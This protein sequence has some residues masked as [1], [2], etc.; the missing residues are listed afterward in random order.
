M[1]RNHVLEVIIYFFVLLG[2]DLVFLRLISKF[3][4]KQIMNVQ[5]E[6]MVI[7]IYGAIACY[8]IIFIALYYFVIRDSESISKAMLLGFVLYGVYE[9][10]SYALLKKWQIQTV[11]IDTLW[12][13]ILLG[14][15][16]FISRNIISYI[17]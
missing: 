15:T 7:N 8:A 6:P 3:F 13:T 11:I 14:L 5:H 16:V 17:H 10:T 9:T 4:S 1:T 2:L 12:G